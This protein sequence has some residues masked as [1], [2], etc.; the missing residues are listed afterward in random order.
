MIF[1][2]A[3]KDIWHGYCWNRYDFRVDD[4]VERNERQ[5]RREIIIAESGYKT[6]DEMMFL[7]DLLQ[8]D[9]VELIDAD[10]ARR[11][12]RVKAENFSHALWPFQPE[13]VE[14]SIRFA[15][16]DSRFTPRLPLDDSRLDRIF[17]LSFSVTAGHEQIYIPFT[18]NVDL[19]IDWGDGTEETVTADNPQHAYAAPGEYTV[20]AAGHAD[21]LQQSNTSYPPFYQAN[22]RHALTAVERWGDLGLKSLEFAFVRCSNLREIERK[23]LYLFKNLTSLAYAFSECISLNAVFESMD[24]PLLQSAAGFCAG[25]HSLEY[26][27][28]GLFAKCPALEYVSYAFQNCLSLVHVSEMLF[29]GCE[30]LTQAEAVFG[31]CVELRNGVTF[32]YNKKIQ[33]FNQLYA[34][35]ANLESIPDYCFADSAATHF[36]SVFQGCTSL[37]SIPAHILSGVGN[38]RSFWHFGESSGLESLPADLFADCPDA[39]DFTYA[40]QAAKM[41]T[42]PEDL[43]QHQT[44]I[45]SFYGT[46]YQCAN[47]AE[48]PAGLFR[49]NINVTSFD[50]CFFG[51]V[52][53]TAV[54]AD[55]FRYCV[56]VTSF[57]YT[58]TNC[59]K[60][61]SVP[62]GLLAYQANA[63][64]LESMFYGCSLIASV[65]AGLFDAIADS[66][67]TR[68]DSCFAHTA[69]T[70]IDGNIFA[71]LTQIT[72]LRYVFSHTPLAVIPAGLLAQNTE[73]V[74]VEGLFEYTDVTDIPEGLFSAC[75][76]LRYAAQLFSYCVHLAA[77]PNLLFDANR[78]ILQFGTVFFNCTA[79]NGASPSG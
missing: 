36:E 78:E 26:I 67:S 40:F 4:Y 18:G 50:S 32:F 34:G 45:T 31:S 60:L 65:P 39:T 59:E 70:A 37:A 11:E 6:P 33:T 16:S 1:R 52:K 8:S 62:A 30:E 46:F 77:I 15:E 72:Q 76:K 22:W 44:G 24:A 12:V 14:L 13:S 5:Q 21:R 47:L 61:T 41:Q 56:N 63:V 58:F 71:H 53:L 17:M 48:V 75:T 28:D 68:V 29:A 7:R 9:R 51:C 27:P 2:N 66:P 10:G 69:I 23:P 25:C 19:L 79:L 55:L 64:N 20:A 57:R 74:N 73:A 43:F 3:L 42:L 49:N 35:C 54:P 38:A